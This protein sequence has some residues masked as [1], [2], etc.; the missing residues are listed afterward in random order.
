MAS[1]WLGTLLQVVLLA[2][3]QS[4][5]AIADLDIVTL[6]SYAHAKCMDGTPAA[7]YVS[8]E[9]KS[10]GAKFV[11]FTSR[12][13]GRC[14]DA[15]ACA[16]KITS[17]LGSSKYFSEMLAGYQLASGDASE[18][19]LLF[20]WTRVFVPYCSQD[21]H[22]GRRTD[23]S[24]VTFGYYFSGHLIFASIIDDLIKTRSL[25]K[26]TDVVLSGGS[27]GGIGT[28]INVDCLAKKVAILASPG[29]RLQAFTTLPIRTTDRTTRVQPLQIFAS[30]RGLP[31]LR[32]GSL[33]FLKDALITTTAKAT[34][35]RDA[36]CRRTLPRT[37][38]QKCL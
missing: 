24:N 20:N 28:W 23:A 3:L 18:N 29:R 32:C 33:T 7:Y 6:S 17:S 38:G 10:D 4:A 15:K 37:L 35:L 34:S 27:A 26:A 22:S 16:A 8:S 5:R 21:L 19:P 9:S 2:L 14:V 31:T 13:A 30:L 25:D 1:F 12:V 36:C 11:V